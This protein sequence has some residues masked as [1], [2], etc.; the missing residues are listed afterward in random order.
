MHIQALP[1]FD[2]NYI[3]MLHDGHEAWVVD[4]GDAAPV[5]SALAEQGLSLQGILI[6]HHHGDHTGG[7]ASLREDWPQAQV[8]APAQEPLRIDHQAMRQDDVVEVLGCPMRVIDV[9]GHTSGHIAYFG[10]PSG[11]TPLLFCGDTL[12]FGGCGRVFEGTPAQMWHSLSQLA[13]LPGDTR[14]CCAHEYTLANLRFALAVEP[15][16]AALQAAATRCQGLR[17]A[18]QATVPS[19]IATELAINPFLRCEVPEVVRAAQSRD[20]AVAGDDPA[21]VFAALREWKNNF[22]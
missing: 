19:D 17:D 1:A 2:D 5:R 7:V 9:P 20:A 8:F 13:A 10:A 4:P 14:V 21:A 11:Q 3:W 18:Q 15:D 16:N 6:T 12:F 22:R